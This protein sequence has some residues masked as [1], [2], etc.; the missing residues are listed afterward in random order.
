MPLGVPGASGVMRRSA[1]ATPHEEG[2][3]RLV[4]SGSRTVEEQGSAGVRHA[5][6]V[7]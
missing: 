7:G 6:Q 3:G 4:P 2:R 1:A 5:P